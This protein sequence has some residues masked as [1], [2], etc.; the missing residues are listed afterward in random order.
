MRAFYITSYSG[1][2][3]EAK[4]KVR[5]GR[6]GPLHDLR[7]RTSLYAFRVSCLFIGHHQPQLVDLRPF[8]VT[9][10]SSITWKPRCLQRGLLTGQ[11]CPST[12][13]L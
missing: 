11:L 5:Q 3:G 9:L 6:T 2:A 12:G 10:L 8:G 7:M 1:E 4:D 13:A